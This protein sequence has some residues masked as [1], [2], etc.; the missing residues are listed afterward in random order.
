MNAKDLITECG[1]MISHYFDTHSEDMHEKLFGGIGE[2]D[3]TDTAMWKIA[4]SAVHYSCS[5]SIM[6]TLIYLM[7]Q[8]LI[9]VSPEDIP[10]LEFS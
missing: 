6:L 10:P 4:V 9:D 7:Q 2:N 3:D 5:T 1:Q 8:G